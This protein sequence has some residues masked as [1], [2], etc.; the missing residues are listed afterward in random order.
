MARFIKN[1]LSMFETQAADI[2]GVIFSLMLDDQIA[3]E[4]LDEL[5]STDKLLG[6]EIYLMAKVLRERGFTKRARRAL[7]LLTNEKK[8]SK[9]RLSDLA[10]LYIKFGLENEGYF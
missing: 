4:I 5:L 3:I 10:D 2:F 6:D 1:K 9:Y 7:G 8:I